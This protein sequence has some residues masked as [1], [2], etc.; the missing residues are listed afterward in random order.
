MQL[1]HGRFP[2]TSKTDTAAA[3]LVVQNVVDMD[4][5]EHNFGVL[6]DTETGAILGMAPLYD[7]NIAL[8]T[9]GFSSDISRAS[10]RLIT[11]FIRLV[12]EEN[13]RMT[14]PA[15]T[16]IMVTK[17]LDKAMS[18]FEIGE[19]PENTAQYIREYII[20]GYRQIMDL[21]KN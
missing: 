2:V 3:Q 11:D 18:C 21:N 16:D 15:L 19:L 12:R 9:R 1:R 7:H 10:D 20:N 17:A 8:V 13:I 14:L 4:R 5:R 6:R